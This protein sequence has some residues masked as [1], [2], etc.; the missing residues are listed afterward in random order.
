[1]KYAMEIAVVAIILFFTAVFAVLLSTGQYEWAGSD[2]QAESVIDEMT[3]TQYEPWISPV[4]EPPSGE[5]ESLFFSLQAALGAIVIGFFFG[6]YYRG[7][8]INT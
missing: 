8:Q 4:Y 6:Y 2:D 1:M 7:R 5:I 3:G